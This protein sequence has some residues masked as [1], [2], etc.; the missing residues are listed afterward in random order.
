M[1]R[2]FIHPQYV[3]SNLKND[4][5][6][7]RLATSVPLGTSPTIG[8]AC[9][10]SILLTNVRCWVSGWGRNDFSSNGAYQAIQREVDV[11]I[12]DQNTCQNNLKTTR[13]GSSF[14]LDFNSF[15]CAGGETGKDA[16]T[17]D[18]GSPLMCLASGQWYVAGLVAWGIGK[19][20]ANFLM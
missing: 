6:I 7:L 20:F 15:M 3:A 8:T 11:P 17:G 18:G 9:I 16:C 14:Q 10:P 2:I 12:V 19:K 4:I 1:T 5:A 13:L